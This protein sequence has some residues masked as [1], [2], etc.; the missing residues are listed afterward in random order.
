M[1]NVYVCTWDDGHKEWAVC[2]GMREAQ[3][4]YATEG[5][6]IKTYR[7]KELIS[8][9]IAYERML[10]IGEAV[11]AADIK[12]AMYAALNATTAEWIEEMGIEI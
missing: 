9:S 11:I 2:G 6:T 3:I 4:V 8:Y 5:C 10:G 1:L 12:R 7:I